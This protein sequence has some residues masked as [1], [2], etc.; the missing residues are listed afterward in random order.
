MSLHQNA[1][2]NHVIKIINI[3]FENVAELKYLGTTV[4]NKNLIHKVSKR[5][6]LEMLATV[7]SRTLS[8]HLLSKNV[9]IT[10]HKTTILPVVLYGCETL[11]LILR[12]GHRLRL[13]GNRVL[14]RIFG[15][16]R[17]K[18]TG[19]WRKLHNEMGMTCSMHGREEECI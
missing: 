7:K 10:I 5:L 17:D 3:S 14:R 13:F 16:K 4:A 2:Q 15:Q 6:N 11:S 9:K 1:G 12:E 19:D 8:S 18:M